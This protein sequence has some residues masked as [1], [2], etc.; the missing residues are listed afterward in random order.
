MADHAFEQHLLH[1]RYADAER[2]AREDAE[3]ATADLQEQ[4]SR[5]QFAA[6][7]LRIGR[8]AR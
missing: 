2:R 5:E 8:R 4:Q 3:Q 7:V 6:V 1:A